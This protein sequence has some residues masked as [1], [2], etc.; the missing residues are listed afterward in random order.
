MTEDW[1][2]ELDRGF[3][4]VDEG[5]HELLIRAPPVKRKNSYGKDQW[6]FE[7]ANMDGVDGMITPPKGLMLILKSA[8]EKRRNEGKDTYPIR[9]EFTRVGMSID[10]KFRVQSSFDEE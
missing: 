6:L 9:V 7:D 2:E 1:E 5:A 4:R 10:S 3:L 8:A